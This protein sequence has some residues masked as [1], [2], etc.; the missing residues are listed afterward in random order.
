MATTTISAALRVTVSREQWQTAFGERPEDDVAG[1]VLAH[2]QQGAD[3]LMNL[4]ARISGGLAA[5]E[6][7]PDWP[8]VV[9]E[10]VV[11]VDEVAWRKN[12]GTTPAVAVPHYVAAVAWQAHSILH[13]AHGTVELVRR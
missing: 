1:Y 2:V 11:A 8:A 12:Y 5:V 6:F 4:G 9:V 3:R 7:D 13:E 10:I